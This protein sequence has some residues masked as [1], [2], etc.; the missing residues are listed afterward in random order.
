MPTMFGPGQIEADALPLDVANVH[1]VGWRKTRS[2]ATA[3]IYEWDEVQGSPDEKPDFVTCSC[4]A[5]MIERKGKYGAFMGCTK[6]PDCKETRK[7]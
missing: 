6:Y 5:M 4:G 3:C 7:L 2:G 1:E